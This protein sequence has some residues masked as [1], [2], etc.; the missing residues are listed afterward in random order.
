MSR[1]LWQ[2][3]EERADAT[4]DARVAV[5]EHRRT[6]TFEQ[7]RDEAERTAAGLL[8]HGVRPSDLVSWQLP[9]ALDT[10]VFT[11]ALARLGAVQNP[12]VMML[13]ERDLGFI[14]RQARTRWLAVPGEFRGTDHEAMAKAVVTGVPGAE[15][16]PLADGLPTGDPATLPPPPSDGSDVRW[17]FYTS[18]TTADPKGAK[19][20]DAGLTAASRTFC[21]HLALRPED[22]TATLL[23]LAHV[24]GVA[25]LLS[26]LQAGSSLIT[27][28]VFDPES[29]PDLLAEQGVTLVGSGLPFI[30]VY[31]ARQR[32]HPDRPLFPLA[33][34]TLCGGSPRPASLHETVRRELGGVGVVSGYGMTECPYL[35]WG[36]WDDSDA[37]HAT[38]EGNAGAGGE[39]VVV[40]P[41]G[42]H[43]GP[44]EI[45]ELRVR[46]PQ[47]MRGYVDSALDA[48]AFDE[49]GYFRSGDLGFRDERGYVTV[50][51]RLKDIIIRKMENISARE[52]EELL[53]GHPRVA[54]V[55]VIGLPDPETGERVCAVVVPVSAEDPPDLTG[56]CDHLLD[57]GLSTRKLPE[58]LELVG[59]LPRNAMGKVVKRDLT[60]RYR[61]QETR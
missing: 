29:T 40:R 10:I 2:L 41:D 23:P 16:L 5:D 30:Q 1:A 60:A 8:A 14:C 22:V 59:A 58:Q 6:L 39:V 18:G 56:L 34:V 21:D 27:S 47:L 61:I 31:L 48:D 46:G 12:L 7:L 55:A 13:R 54:D 3:V 50:T 43:A 11:L 15:V 25:H 9:T 26:A 17:I 4:P 38:S 42:T 37:A 51:G 52:L 20:T 49:N 32:L 45:G 28:A 24:G 57:H 19:H 53:I 44:G 36:H 35:T 33:R